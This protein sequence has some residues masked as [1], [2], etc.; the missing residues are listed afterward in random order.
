MASWAWERARMSNDGGE[1]SERFK[2]FINVLCG[3]ESGIGFC[4]VL[5]AFYAVRYIIMKNSDRNSEFLFLRH[6]HV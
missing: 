1:G 6:V 5:V 3:F 2:Y 4:A